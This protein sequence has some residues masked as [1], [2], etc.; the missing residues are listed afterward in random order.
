MT[1][2]ARLGIAVLTATFLA[3][4]AT[5]GN[6][7][8]EPVEAPSGG[9][10]VG[11]TATPDAD[12]YTGRGGFVPPA[13]PGSVMG[14]G[15]VLQA[16]E[17]LP[18]F[19]LGGVQESYPPQCTG[20]ELLGWDWDQVQQS[21]RASGV[22]WGT[23]AVT[24]TWN[25]IRFTPTT[26]PIPLSLYDAMPFEDPLAGRQ[27]SSAP[28]ELARILQDIFFGFGDYPVS[29]G[30]E[31]SSARSPDNTH[32]AGHLLVN[33][34]G[35]TGERRAQASGT[36]GSRGF[37]GHGE[38]WARAGLRTALSLRIPSAASFTAASPTS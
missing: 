19:C 18:R 27:G 3:A 10:I 5:P 2:S 25:G 12:S 32:A 26:A 20:P 34:M 29:G 33:D 28:Q 21:E 16:G 14:Q 1:W 9:P 13:A 36:S 15:T 35:R 38:W 11:P 31:S 6:P 7:G 8:S 17:A 22:T 4:C 23:F 30:V 37:R 24:G